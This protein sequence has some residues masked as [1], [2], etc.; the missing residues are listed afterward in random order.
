MDVVILVGNVKNIFLLFWIRN[1]FGLSRVYSVSS[2]KQRD[3]FAAFRLF[4]TVTT[5]TKKSEN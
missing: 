5:I 1:A 4:S 2:L 3:S